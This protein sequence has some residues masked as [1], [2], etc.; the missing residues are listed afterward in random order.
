MKTKDKTAMIEKAY[1]LGFSYEQNYRGCAQCTVAAVQE[2]LGK[3]NP[4]LFRAASGL[5]AGGGLTCQGSCGG[6]AGGIMV[7]SSF[8]GRRQ[9]KF[10]NDDDY[11]NCAFRMAQELQALF[12]ETYGSVICGTI[13][14]AILGRTY[15]LQDLADKK[16]FNRD[17]A[18]TDKCTKVVATTAAWTTALI[19]HEAEKRGLEIAALS[20]N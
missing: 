6:F 11:K 3:P 20:S 8:F 18:H 10:N 17:G 5:S 1:E 2:A 7:M 15:N 19:L 12:T 4:V 13:H 16:Q 14:K 9:E